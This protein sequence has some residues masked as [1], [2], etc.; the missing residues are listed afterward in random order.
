MICPQCKRVLVRCR[1]PDHNEV[2]ES[3]LP[4]DLCRGIKSVIESNPVVLRSKLD[5]AVNGLKR[6]KDELDFVL[7]QVGSD[8]ENG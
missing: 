6:I 2:V 3:H 8:K 5:L 7:N 1:C 4:C